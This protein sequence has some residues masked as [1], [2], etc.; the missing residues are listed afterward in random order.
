MGKTVLGLCGKNRIVILQ[1]VYLPWLGYFDQLDQAD[2]FVFFDDVQYTDRDWRN[3]NRIKTANGPC[4]LTVPVHK[5]RGMTIRDVQISNIYG[6]VGK[7]LKSFDRA[8]AKAP[9][10]VEIMGLL[11]DVLSQKWE[12]LF[13]L[14]IALIHAIMGYVGIMTPTIFASQIGGKGFGRTERLV[15]ICNKLN[16]SEYLSG[17]SAKNYLD[18]SLFG[19]TEV[20]W[21][22]YNHPEYRQQWG[23]FMSHMSIM[24]LLFNYG[25]SSL[26]IIRSGRCAA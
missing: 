3:R 18:K 2:I 21:H 26:S 15:H 7:H 19:N 25:P 14:D 10:F 5:S 11:V 9:Y 12:R 4:W 8:Y 16:P 20:K 1:P 23:D 24:D 13:E 17:A 22:E 6:W